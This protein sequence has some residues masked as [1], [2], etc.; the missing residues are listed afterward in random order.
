MGI[1]TLVQIRDEVKSSMGARSN[2]AN[3]RFN[4]WIN[5]AYIDIASGIDFTELDGV[6]VIP[7][8][9]GQ[10]NYTGPVNPLIVQLVRDDTNNNLLQWIPESEYFR[11]DRSVANAAPERWTRRAAE[12]LLWPNPVAIV[13]LSAL[14]KITPTALVADGDLTILPPY[15]DNALI[16]LGTAYG[17]LAVNE[18]QR[19]IVWANRAVTYLSSR[20]TGQDFSFLLGG[21]ANTQPSVTQAVEA[22]AS[23]T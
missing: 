2:L 17:L 21:L 18:D 4:T 13:S 8:V 6:L 16:L 1:L 5:L 23:A 15:V 22:S 11:L 19:A 12:I 14:F 20:L 7:T 3:V 9:V 10:N